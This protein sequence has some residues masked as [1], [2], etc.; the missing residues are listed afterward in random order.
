VI[1]VDI[2]EKDSPSIDAFVNKAEHKMDYNIAYSGEQDGMAATWM[3]ASGSKGVP[4]TF[5]VKDRII[6]WIGHPIDLEKTLDEVIAGTFNVHKAQEAFRQAL[7]QA[8]KGAELSKA[9]DEINAQ[10][11]SGDAKGAHE[12]LSMTKKSRPSWDG[13]EILETSWL[14][15]RNDHSFEKAIL[16]LMEKGYEGRTIAQNAF[17][18]CMKYKRAH[19]SI[20]EAA[21][22]ILA[23]GTED[24]NDY[25]IAYNAF[26]GLGDKP[27]IK[28]AAAMLL[29]AFKKEGK[30]DSKIQKQL[31]QEA[32]GG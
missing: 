30:T 20:R 19:K 23:S 21:R 17:L 26:K 1:A 11:W 7:I 4:T 8:A 28:R 2:W 12:K 25:M 15:A 18:R 10:F 31:E 13:A 5:I 14:A 16:T 32:R 22:A 29:Q 6:Q 9:M 3:A 24:G 27:G